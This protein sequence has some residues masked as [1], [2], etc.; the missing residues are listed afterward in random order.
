MIV[1]IGYGFNTLDFSKAEW[2]AIYKRFDAASF[3]EYAKDK[4]EE[5]IESGILDEINANYLSPTD[6]L[7]DVI[8]GSEYAESGIENVV[9][10]YDDYIVFDSIRFAND[11]K[12]AQHVKC[13]ADFVSM[14]GKYIPTNN[15]RFGNLYESSSDYTD[16]TYFFD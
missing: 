9:S 1:Y 16:P 3:D 14:I 11:C 8:C 15:I 4:S 7:R 10:C 6:Y 13:A 5:D 12:R 2:V